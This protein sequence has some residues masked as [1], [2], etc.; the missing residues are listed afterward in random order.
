[1][2]PDRTRP[3][4]R[5]EQ[6]LGRVASIHNGIGDRPIKCQPQGV[7]MGKMHVIV[8]AMASEPAGIF[9]RGVSRR[10]KASSAGTSP[11]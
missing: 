3:V 7:S 11:M 6:R 10:G 1:M 8:I 4:A 5:L 2:K 9:F